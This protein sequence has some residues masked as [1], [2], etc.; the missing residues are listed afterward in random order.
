M[1]DFDIVDAH[2]H[3]WDLG[4]LSYPWLQESSG[5]LRVHGDDS[6]LHQNFLPA[7]YRVALDGLPIARTVHVDAGA[8]DGLA[9][10]QWLE[11]VADEHAIP[12][13]I[14][15]SVRLDE[16]AAMET[17]EQV[18]ALPRV[19]GIRHILNW[20]EDPGLTYT[21]RPGIMTEERFRTAFGL[22]APLDLSFDLQVY[23][24]QFRESAELAAAHPDTSIVLNHAGMPLGRDADAMDQWRSGMRILAAQP[25]CSVKISGLGMTDHHWTTESIRPLVLETIEIFGHERCMFGS[26][27]PVDRL[28]SSAAT[29]YAAFDEITADFTASERRALFAGNADRVYRLVP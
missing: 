25:N 29:L 22:L 26:N 9:E 4:S 7:D 1:F 8:A 20:H 17:L 14:V 13:G 28:Y 3:L 27:F 23:P 10:A 11:H 16:P 5:K 19:R 24:Q 2:H 18:A 21:D 12:T 6:A 15:A